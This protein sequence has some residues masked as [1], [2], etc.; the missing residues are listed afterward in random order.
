MTEARRKMIE[1]MQLRGLSERTQEA[2]LGAVRELAKFYM[3]PPAELSDDEVRRYFLHLVNE[4]RASFSKVNLSIC[5]LKFFYEKSLGKEW[6]LS[7]L[8]RP[9]PRK[10]L[11]VVLSRT[12]VRTL[13]SLVRVPKYRT[14]LTLI[15]ACGLRLKEALLLRVDDVDTDRAQLRIRNGKGGKDRYVPLSDKALEILQGRRTERPSS[16]LFCGRVADRHLHP[17]AVQ[18]MFKAVVVQSGIKKAATVHTLRHSFATHMLE[19][20]VSIRVIQQ[21]LGHTSPR[22]TARYTHLTTRTVGQ[23]R[24]ALDDVLDEL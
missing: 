24:H 22:T 2:Y 20:G 4:K 21:M 11:P 1:D 15:Y 5:A 7:G 12:E 3:R 8:I 16:Y 9:K 18:R 23:A 6:K 14:A 19:S 10:K 13:L 17:S